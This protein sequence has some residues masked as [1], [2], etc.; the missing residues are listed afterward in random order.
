MNYNKQMFVNLP[1]KSL[2][3]AVEFFTGLG[4]NFNPKFTDENATCMI[5]GNDCYVMLLAEPFFKSFTDKE[6]ADV[7]RSTEVIVSISAESREKVDELVNKAFKMGA[8][9]AMDKNDM[10]FMY[11]WSFHDLD[12][13]HWEVFWKDENAEQK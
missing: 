1:V 5:V 8:K 4:F 12:G 11:N 6:I 10:G 3:R 2:P 7:S 9:P 13:H